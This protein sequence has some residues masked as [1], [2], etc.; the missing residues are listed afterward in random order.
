MQQQRADN[1]R[2][3]RKSSRS[4]N[5]GTVRTEGTLEN[6]VKRGTTPQSG[7]HATGQLP[8]LVPLVAPVT[9]PLEPPPPPTRAPLTDEEML[10]ELRQLCVDFVFP[11]YKQIVQDTLARMCV[12]AKMG[13]GVRDADGHVRLHGG[14]MTVRPYEERLIIR[15]ESKSLVVDVYGGNLAAP[16][17]RDKHRVATAA[18]LARTCTSASAMDATLYEDINTKKLPIMR[19]LEEI[20][21]VE[22]MAVLDSAQVPQKKGKGAPQLSAASASQSMNPPTGSRTVSDEKLRRN[23][24]ADAI[25]NALLQER[26][27]RIR[28]VKT[29][30]PQLKEIRNDPAVTMRAA[31]QFFNRTFPKA[32]EI[33]SWEDPKNVLRAL[34]R[35]AFMI[36]E[37]E[38]RNNPALNYNVRCLRPELVM[39]AGDVAI[40]WD[41]YCCVRNTNPAKVTTLR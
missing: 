12:Y 33:R 7:G 9:A 15:D 41:P 10:R 13:P 4:H 36:A 40:G 25:A 31:T 2:E 8:P 5:S 18:N 3:S 19:D 23:A 24:L 29:S 21:R 14:Y 39:N 30:S 35:S 37:A 1:S 26:I 20:S 32:H 28:A 34:H 16:L 22:L 38:D 17:A 27:R 6:S 11:P